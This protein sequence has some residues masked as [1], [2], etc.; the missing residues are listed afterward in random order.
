M[1]VTLEYTVANAIEEALQLA[2][3]TA[4]NIPADAEMTE[5][6]RKALRRMLKSWQT[7][8]N[9]E[10]LSTRMSHTITVGPEQ[11]LTPVRPVRLH[12]VRVKI[13]GVETILTRLSEREYDDLPNKDVTG[14]PSQYYYDRQREAARLY[15]YPSLG[16]VTTETLEITYEREFEDFDATSETLDVTG[17][18]WDA[19]VYNLASRMRTEVGLDPRADLN[20]NAGALLMDLM[21]DQDAEDVYFQGY[22]YE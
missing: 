17:E 14:T 8:G 16:T 19:V 10:W 22:S 12:S 13:S 18:A 11:T 4:T 2:G 20:M 21:A 7:K 1:P 9:F 3:I 15:L 5:V 6:A